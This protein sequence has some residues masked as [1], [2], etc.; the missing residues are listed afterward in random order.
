MNDYQP[1]DVLPADIQNDWGARLEKAEAHP[2]GSFHLVAI[3]RTDA[4]SFEGQRVTVLILDE[5]GN[6][7]PNIR[8]AFSYST[9]DRY[10]L[11]PDF[12]WR[13]PTPQRAFIVPTQGSGQIDQIQGGG[14][15]PG[16][17]GGIT[18]Y[19]FEP[20]F[21]SDVVTGLGMLADHTGLHLTFQLRR[22]GV[23]STGE[24]L[25]VLEHWVTVLDGR[26]KALE[27]PEGD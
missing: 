24:R 20:K 21:S 14:V 19:I 12:T 1:L 17:P 13:P 7:L 23:R 10:T 15:K 9:A 3:R 11:T 5:N 22:A 6:P 2:A 26:L 25:S 4:A 27:G 18:V 16:E 8:V